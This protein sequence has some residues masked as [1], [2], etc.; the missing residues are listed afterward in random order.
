MGETKKFTEM[1]LSDANVA[2]T[3]QGMMRAL[4]V[5]INKYSLP[6][7]DLEGCVND[8]THVEEYLRDLFH[9]DADNLRVLTDEAA[10]TANVKAEL[11]WLVENTGAGDDAVYWHSGHGTSIYDSSGDEKDYM[12]ECLVMHDSD[13]D[14][15]FLDDDLAAILKTMND[16][17]FFTLVFDTCYSGG[18]YRGVLGDRLEAKNASARVLFPPDGVQSRWLG[19]FDRTRRFGVKFQ[20]AETQRH[21]L[22]SGC[23]ETG[24]CEE[25]VIGDEVGGVFTASFLRMLKR[26]AL[27]LNQVLPNR[28][29]YKFVRRL[30]RRQRYAQVPQLIGPQS[31]MARTVFGGV[32]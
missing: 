17:G 19:K 9:I 2:S 26:R 21:L 12:D 20:K 30:M 16:E 7:S 3:R 4:L 5:G 11:Q 29:H 22:F 31:M 10:T 24:Y 32:A 15:M 1:N 18:M 8:V 28:R 27:K 14:S 6:G 25:T 23:E 13:W